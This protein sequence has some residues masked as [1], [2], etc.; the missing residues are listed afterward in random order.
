MLQ[1]PQRDIEEVA[2]ES[3]PEMV[4]ELF[5]SISNQPTVASLPISSTPMTRKILT[6][7]QIKLEPSFSVN[8]TNPPTQPLSPLAVNTSSVQQLSSS[9]SMDSNGNERQ[10]CVHPSNKSYHL[11]EVNNQSQPP[12][13][14]IQRLPES[15]STAKISTAQA[16]NGF[17]DRPII[18][19]QKD[20][21]YS[22]QSTNIIPKMNGHNGIDLGNQSL[23]CLLE[24][25][26]T[27]VTDVSQVGLDDIQFLTDILQT[28]TDEQSLKTEPL[29]SVDSSILL[30]SMDVPLYADVNQYSS[31]L[32]S[33]EI[34]YKDEDMN[35]IDADK[36]DEQGVIGS[37]SWDTSSSASSASSIGSHFEFSYSQ[38]FSDM[39]SSDFGVSD[40]IDWGSVD[41]IKI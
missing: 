33:F 12:F 36:N 7:S 22:P 4:T 24:E 13:N 35:E 19:P 30:D 2:I 40:I 11:T 6:S 10:F 5:D 15:L 1:P 8:T 16:C 41:M 28:S 26:R 25:D 34:S 38:D 21:F 23:R 29:K 18:L 39:V 20:N 27:R 32:N 9:I 31:N 17:N 3:L 14:A 37:S